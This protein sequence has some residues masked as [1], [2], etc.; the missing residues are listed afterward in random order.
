MPDTATISLYI[1]R[2]FGLKKEIEEDIKKNYDSRIVDFIK[3]NNYTISEGGITIR[4]AKEFGFCYGVDRAVEYAYETRKKFPDKKIYITGEIIHNPYV[5]NRLIEMGV[6]FLSGPYQKEKTWANVAKDDVVILPAFGVTIKQM[7]NLVDIGCIVVDTTCG[8]VLNVWKNVEKYAKDGFTSVVHGKYYHEETQA[9]CSRALKYPGGQYLVIRDI[10]EAEYVYD[11]ILNGGS[12]EDFY[13]KFSKAI[14]NG[15]DPNK[16]LD[17][18]GVANQTTMLSSESLQISKLFG[19]TLSKKFG[20]ENLDKHFRNFDTICSA[21][22]ERQDAII[23]LLKE[24]L[25]MMVIIG[26][27]NSSNTNNLVAISVK[28]VK[29]FHIEDSN[30]IEGKEK[31]RHKLYG[32]TTETSEENWIPTDRNLIIGLTAGASTPN[33]KIAGAVE[34]IFA[35]RGIEIGKIIA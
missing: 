5:N 33:Y 26:G 28:N 6:N 15:F 21:T 32:Q 27:Y 2:G 25:D 29:T 1:K 8:S 12:T 34:K 24:K 22:Q 7:E 17:K 20:A 30:C 35:T 14:S 23:E 9:T 19:E 31:I 10:I 3:E 13:K 18:I 11:F 16:H 4:L